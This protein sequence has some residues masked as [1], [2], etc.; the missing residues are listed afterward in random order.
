MACWA[1]SWYF[2]AAALRLMSL[3]R[4]HSKVLC[5]MVMAVRGGPV[6]AD[7]FLF[8]KICASIGPFERGHLYEDPLDDLLQQ[9]GL[10]AVTGGG[11]ALETSSEGRAVAWCGIDIDLV[12]VAARADALDLLRERLPGLGAPIGSELQYT[13]GGRQL[14]DR[15]T[16]A[17]WKRE[18]DG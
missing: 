14:V 9:R 5:A 3:G 12:D 8:V 4:F 2:V 18:L 16:A 6:S 13:A 7:A 11:T 15:L 17:G 1:G 10:G